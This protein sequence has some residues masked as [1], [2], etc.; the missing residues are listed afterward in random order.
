VEDLEITH[1]KQ[2]G[3]VLVEQ[4]PVLHSGSEELVF[5]TLNVVICLVMSVL[6]HLAHFFS[7]SPAVTPTSRSK[8]VPQSLHLYE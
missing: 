8:A 2:V 1:Q 4:E 5:P 7:L 3:Q 6:P